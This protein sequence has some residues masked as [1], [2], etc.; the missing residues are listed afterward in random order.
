[1]LRL[2][3]SVLAAIAGAYLALEVG[4][5]FWVQRQTSGEGRMGAEWALVYI[6]PASALGCGILAAALTRKRN[7]G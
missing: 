2:T 7:Q 6:V 1:M 5:R 4:E 3:M